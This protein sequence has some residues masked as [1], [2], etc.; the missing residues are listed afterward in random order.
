[1]P[2]CIKMD[3]FRYISSEAWRALT[4]IEMGLKNHEVVPPELAL[5]I[6]HIKRSCAGF[7]RLVQEHLI[8]YSLVAYETDNRHSTK[9]YRLTNMGY[10]YLALNQFFK[11]EQLS[12]LGTMVG[13]GKESDVYI[14]TAGGRCGQTSDESEGLSEGLPLEG[15]LVIVKFHRLGRTSFR[16]VKN[17]REYHQHRNKCSWLYLDRLASKREFEMMQGLYNNG[18]P[19]PMPYAHNRNA[20]LMS[21]VKESSPLYRLLPV[22]LSSNQSATAR[23]L[24]Y[25]AKDILEKIAG[26]GLVHGDFNEFNLMVTGLDSTPNEKADTDPKL[27]LIDF[28]QMIS[29]DH[30]LAKSIYERDV[31]GVV[32][33]FSRYFEIPSDDLPS[34]LDTIKRTSD[35]DVQLKAP[36]YISHNNN[37]NNHRR[38]RHTVDDSL[39]GTVAR[40]Q[41]SSSSSTE[42]E[43]ESENGESEL[44]NTDSAAESKSECDNEQKSETEEEE[45]ESESDEECATDSVKYSNTAND[46]DVRI[47]K[48]KTAPSAF[49]VEEI[50]ERQR[51]ERR[52][53]KQVDF[54]RQLK[55]HNRAAMKR[56]GRLNMKAE[57]L[58]FG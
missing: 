32:N 8:P 47:M 2:K 49:T 5:K 21:Y 44:D 24:Y 20:V 50:R 31:E 40:L 55:R 19:V 1:M 35:I 45:S 53:Q 28:P 48:T 33:F 43:S 30:K 10:D 7:I 18:V 57:T 51:R 22:V 34:S 11:S 13:A 46:T 39:L 29:R 17:K 37:N 25:Q 58:L 42:G 15:D 23:A 3:R 52:R 38:L 6:S 26:L 4:A 56:Q 41:L 9:G 14:G 27:V 12:S 36:G 54:N 16:K